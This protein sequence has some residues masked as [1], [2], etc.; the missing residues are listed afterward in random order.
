MS[1]ESER[2]PF[3]LHRYKSLFRVILVTI[4]AD[5]VLSCAV[6]FWFKGHPDLI[7]FQIGVIPTLVVINLGSAVACRFAAPRFYLVLLINS[8][9]SPIL[10]YLIYRFFA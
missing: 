10:F 3:A 2:R 8:V 1:A 4:V 9:L 5:V 7:V 6:I